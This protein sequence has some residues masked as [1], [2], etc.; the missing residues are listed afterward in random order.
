MMWN[1]LLIPVVG[2][3]IGW[4][5]NVIA[6]KLLFHPYTGRF[7]IQGLLP[8]NKDETAKRLGKIVKE[9]LLDNETLISQIL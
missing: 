5:T 6:I 1:K 8:K 7:G 9:H 2:A 4:I 3:F